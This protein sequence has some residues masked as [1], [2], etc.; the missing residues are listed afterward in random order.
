MNN[1]QEIQLL[2]LIGLRALAEYDSPEYKRSTDFSKRELEQ[3]IT[4]LLEKSNSIE[5][6]DLYNKLH[7]V[8]ETSESPVELSFLLQ[9]IYASSFMNAQFYALQESKAQKTYGDM[10][11][12]S[13]P[14]SANMQSRDKMAVSDES[15]LIRLSTMLMLRDLPDYVPIFQQNIRNFKVDC[16]L[17]PKSSDLPFIVIEAK[18]KVRNKKQLETITELLGGAM[19]AFG[20]NTIGIIV[21]EFTATEEFIEGIGNNM[22]LLEFD[23]R[24][25]CFVGDGFKK[26]IDVLSQIYIPL[27]NRSS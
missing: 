25:N 18:S 3:K 4:N 6:N 12:D 11:R 21:I 5:C 27:T 14:Q 15:E 8:I 23:I 7:T 20:K 13:R 16:L 22:Y 19:Q 2:G 26:L 24:K 10:E 9:Q 17:E 1:V